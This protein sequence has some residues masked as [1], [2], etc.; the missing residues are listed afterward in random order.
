MPRLFILVLIC[1]ILQGCQGP[2]KVTDSKQT[3]NN[4]PDSTLAT[5]LPQDGWKKL[6]DDLEITLLYSLPVTVTDTPYIEAQIGF[7][8][9]RFYYYSGNGSSKIIF[10]YTVSSA[11]LDEDGIT[12]AHSI[13]LNGGSLTYSP[14]TAVIENVPT[15]LE[16]PNSQ[17]NVD[18]IVPYFTAMTV[19]VGGNYSIG[20]QLK[21]RLTYSEEVN[22]TGVPGFNLNLGSGTVVAKY[23]SGSGTTVL[24]FSR[25]VAGESDANGFTTGTTLSLS[26]I[27]G[28]TILDQAGNSISNFI[29]S[30]TS[31][32]ILVNVIL[33]TIM[34]VIPPAATTYTL[35]QNLDFTLNM[36][37]ATNVTGSPSLPVVLNTGTVLAT[38]LSGTGTSSLVFRYT[39]QTNHVDSDG[40]TLFSPMLLNGGT[41]KNLLGTQNAA[42]LYTV[43]STAGRLVNA[44]TGP[45]VVSTFKP[46]N[47]IYLEGA[48]NLEFT[49]NFS[50]IVN[51]IGA[52]RLPIIVG[53][54]TVYAG[55][56]SGS[57]TSALKFRYTPIIGQEDLD[58]VSLS[59]PIDLFGGTI[60]DIANRAAILTY[61]TPDTTGIL[62]DATFPSVVD[63]STTSFGTLLAGQ[64]LNLSVQFSEVVLVAGAPTLSL[65]VGPNPLQNAVYVSGSG[66]NTLNFSYTILASDKDSNGIDITSPLLLN[67]GSIKDL[68][69]HN[70]S[71]NFAP[72]LTSGVVI[73]ADAS[74]ILSIAP[75]GN[76]TYKTGA[77]LNFTVTWTE[78]TYVS[79]S[80]RLALTVGA[81]IVY[82]TYVSSPT[83]STSLFRYTVQTGHLDTDGIAPTG[84]QLN[85]G[86]IRDAAGNNASLTYTPIM[87]PAVLPAVLVD[88]VIPRV[89]SIT[90]PINN[91][92][93]AGQVLSFTLNWS[94]PI[95]VVGVPTLQLTI[96]TTVVSA[97]FISST[98]STTT[99]SYT[100][101]TN[102]LDTNGISML[103]A[104]FL[105]TGA[106][107]KDL[108]LNNAYLQIEPPD[109]TGVKVDAIAPMISAVLS[110]ANG[111]YKYLD[112]MDFTVLWSEAVTITGLPRIGIRIGP[113]QYYATYFGPGALPNSSIFRYT[114]GDG[115]P[116]H[117]ED[118]SDANGITITSNI[119]DG[120][121]NIINSYIELNSGTIR[122]VALNVA[123]VNFLAPVLTGVLVD[124]ITAIVDP[125]NP[126]TTTMTSGVYCLTVNAAYCPGRTTLSFTVH[127]TK[128]IY[129]TGTPTIQVNV[130]GT[131]KTASYSSGTATPDL[132]F[133]YVIL[134]GDFDSDGITVGTQPVDSNGGLL[135]YQYNLIS[136]IDAKLDFV[137]STAFNATLSG[138]TVDAVAPVRTAIIST[139]SIFR[140][141]NNIDYSL[142]F[143]EAV[144]VTGTPTLAL[145]VG[146]VAQSATNISGSTTNTLI[147]RYTV[148]AAN[149]YLDLDGINVSSTLTL[150]AVTIR[151]AYGNVFTNGGLAFSEIDYVYYSNTLAR[152]KASSYT[153]NTLASC[154]NC[155]TNIIDS[156]GNS[157][158]LIPAAGAFGPKFIAGTSP[159]LKFDNSSMLK[160]TTNLSIKYVVF[161]MRTV[162]SYVP[163]ET[164]AI[165]NHRL[166]Q[167]Y[168]S[169]AF[170]PAI[171]FTSNSVA[172]S[173]LFNPDQK[174]K[175]NDTLDFA[176]T[177]EASASSPSLWATDTPYI[178]I[179]ELDSATTFDIGSYFGGMDF[180]GQ[181]AEIILLDGTDATFTEAKLNTLRDQL[182]AIHLVY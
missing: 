133:T 143:N 116:S 59:G 39:V 163:P 101:L 122:D 27:A 144:T 40:I 154:P 35:G 87:L 24:E 53:S 140:P 166:L 121:G 78:A 34:S 50:S 118:E 139:N 173:I 2:E 151:D 43:P 3:S 49:L 137:A 156:S 117:T 89:T 75:P 14:R 37:E 21:Y 61:A 17:I 106:S 98:A 104:V 146:G 95:T 81:A 4:F 74:G 66:T 86:L 88:G 128:N 72:E 93:G 13:E 32:D 96:G 145:S 103:S 22:V 51:V 79:G 29:P 33:P 180:N 162:E 12:F 123:D 149:T 46:A 107:I 157:N 147:F 160:T 168:S 130:G 9:R 110:P 56:F 8:T 178:M 102:Q 97:L 44:A 77:S 18:G 70:S 126:I 23:K 179:F 30:T 105:P 177:W 142:T 138:I 28:I 48:A 84:F 63:A 108:A 150:T 119:L 57:G 20:Q 114:I 19:P 169:A 69:G 76:T 129:V 141:G 91:Y 112:K 176:A 45:Y 80:P 161:V 99:F 135:R 100:I 125:T 136:Y 41:I 172:K 111:T 124:G 10:R 1:F 164:I 47:G 174:L 16:I 6:G 171:E 182:N 132:T 38:Y 55:Y 167:R 109:L 92:Y 73:D 158:H 131:S 127:W 153:S 71:L 120:L 85:G 68:R 155:V 94:E 134:A 26:T 65:T 170:T 31:N 62:V 58:G 5:I 42:L 113:T 25:I 175:I 148:P 83:P 159:Y 36:S 7:N 64:N 165:S 82:A 115:N 67:G 11:D 152:Y 54:T 181:I 52:P 90:P 60:K 15:D